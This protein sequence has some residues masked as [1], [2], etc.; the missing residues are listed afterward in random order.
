M[1]TQSAV[2]TNGLLENM[3]TSF[4]NRIQKIQNTFQSSENIAESFHFLF[5]NVHVVLTDL[6]AQRTALNSRLCETLAKNVSMRKTDYHLMMASILEAVDEKEREAESQ[7]LAFIAAQKQTV[8][9]LKNSLLEIKDISSQDNCEK[10][11]IVKEQ[12]SQISILQEMRKEMA[13]KTFIDFRKMHNKMKEYFENLLNKGADILLRDI[14]N[15]K[16]QIITQ[17]I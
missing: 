5:D 14:K 12:L 1:S 17:A 6:K 4:E 16:Y 9:S 15:A 13:L 11:A 7:F 8:Q 2:A 10:I 3:I